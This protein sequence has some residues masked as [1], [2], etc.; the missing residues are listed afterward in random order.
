MKRKKRSLPVET[1][2]RNCGAHLSGRYC[3]ECGQDVLKGTE[4][5]VFRLSYIAIENAFSLDNKIFVT[6]KR[7]LFSPGYLSKEYV[8]GHIARYVHPA[9]LFWFITLLLFMV[10]AWYLAREIDTQQAK[11]KNKTGTEQTFNVSSLIDSLATAGRIKASDTAKLNLIARNAQDAIA[12]SKEKDKENPD[13]KYD[14]LKRFMSNAT[15]YLPY[16]SLFFIPVFAFLLL[17]FFRRKHLA[18][19]DHFVFALHFHAFVFLLLLI[20]I[21]LVIAF[22]KLALL[23]WIMLLLPYI[24]FSIAVYHFYKPKITG[25]IFRSLLAAFIYCILLSTIIGLATAL[26]TKGV[27]W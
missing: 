7:L 3:H 20:S 14:K 11:Q 12:I 4:K 24:Y 22:P 16:I 2:C 1:Q 15:T 8:K 27:Y 23:G 6:L 19:I 21:L 26:F 9:K 5:S 10:T 17:L 25:L 18:Y 13:A